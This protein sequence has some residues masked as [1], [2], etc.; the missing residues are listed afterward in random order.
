VAKQ[1][2]IASDLVHADETGI[3]VD[4]KRIWLHN[5]SNEK[6]TLFFPHLK[7]GCEAMNE[8]KQKKRGRT[9]EQRRATCLN[10]FVTLKMMY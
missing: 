7:R 9:K 1:A 2:L 4:G 3:N 6:W 5:A 10:G 8:P